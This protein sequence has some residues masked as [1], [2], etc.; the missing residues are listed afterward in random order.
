MPR[1]EP[2][3]QGRFPSNLSLMTS[4]PPRRLRLEASSFCQL[5]CPECAH[6]GGLP[7]LDTTPV[8][9]G[10]IRF[11]HFKKFVDDN[12]RVSAIELSNNGEI[13]VNKD[14]LRIVEYAAQ[15]GV[16]LSADN[17]VNLNFLRDD[18][19]E[20]LVRHRFRSLVCSIDGATNET[21]VKYRV[22]GN[23]ERVLENIRLINRYKAKWKSGLPVLTWKYILFPH[24]SHEVDDARRLAKS[25]GMSFFVARQ[26]GNFVVDGGPEKLI[27]ADALKRPREKEPERRGTRRQIQERFD[28]LARR[29][30]EFRL[31]Y[32]M[33]NEP[34][35]NFNGD[36]LGC[37]VNSWGAYGNAFE[38]PLAEV[39][40]GDKMSTARN[41]LL[42]RVPA[43]DDIPCTQCGYYQDMKNRRAW[44]TKPAIQ[45]G[46][47]ALSV[48]TVLRRS[49]LSTVEEGVRLALTRVRV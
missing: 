8:G 46:S 23:L 25:L 18:V 22:G 19:A 6:G 48:I 27:P 32:Q 47:L 20:G 26:W 33:W 43:R 31:C 34:Q 12:P 41:M 44:L 29:W 36:V 35:V 5:E 3:F 49:P 4:A 24:N 10:S 14:L 2:C 9:L 28:R 1:P 21:Y 7:R 30:T 40:R 13:F 39:L 17:G 37:C 42:G 16:R 11:E 15:K 38:Q 45:L